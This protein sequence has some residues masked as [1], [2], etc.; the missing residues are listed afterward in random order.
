[1]ALKTSAASGATEVAIAE[2]QAILDRKKGLL[3]AKE[4]ELERRLSLLKARQDALVQENGGVDVRA[5][6]RM[7]LNVGGVP[8]RATRA[9]LT[10]YNGSKLAALFSGRWEKKLLRDRQGRVF[11]DVH[12]GCFRKIVDFLNMLAIAGGEDDTEFPP[13]APDDEH[14]MAQLLHFIGLAA[15]VAPCVGNPRLKCIQPYMG[16]L[17]SWLSEAEAF[18]VGSPPHRQIFSLY[19]GSKDGFRAA[20]FHAM[21]DGKGP[22]LTVIT[23]TAGHVFGGYTDQSWHS[24]TAYIASSKAF[25]FV[26][27]CYSGREPVKIPLNPRHSDHATYGHPNLGPTF[28]GGH[29]LYVADNCNTNPKSVFNLDRVRDGSHYQLPPGEVDGTFVAGG[30]HFSVHDIE[31]FGV[32][33]RPTGATAPMAFTAAKRTEMGAASAQAWRTERFDEFHATIRDAL[34]AE[35]AALIEDE[36]EVDDLEDAFSEEEAFVRVVSQGGT[37]DIVELDVSGEKMAVKRSTLMLCAESALARKFDDKVWT[38]AQEIEGRK[39]PRT[40]GVTE[41]MAWVKTIEGVTP[42]VVAEFGKNDYD[43]KALLTL[44]HE[45][46]KELGVTKVPVRREILDGIEKLR[47]AEGG[48]SSEVFIDQSAYCF[49]KIVN[50]LRLRAMRLPGAP[51]LQGP[52]VVDHEKRHFERIV[53]YFF[54][55][56]EEFVTSGGAETSESVL[57]TVPH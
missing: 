22:T 14:T 24:G 11:L 29:N 8:V 48:A 37:K 3:R 17:T 26:L 49:G 13:V 45:D 47:E 52:S 4:D 36:A 27:K 18:D 21:C 34:E 57:V 53:A 41:V 40:W 9:T 23:T 1:M 7:E 39:G 30:R 50:Q 10:R 42:E 5:T 38:Q 16:H 31:V 56:V 6:D 12:P 55:G 54:P 2:L 44:Q 20:Q 15:V 51:P 28:G 33:A 19:C 43:G 32:R 35:Q 46:L 25:L